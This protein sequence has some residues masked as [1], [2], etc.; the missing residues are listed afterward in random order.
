MYL[1]YYFWLNSYVIG[2]RGEWNMGF[3]KIETDKI[4]Q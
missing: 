4:Y 3:L 1:T 2:R